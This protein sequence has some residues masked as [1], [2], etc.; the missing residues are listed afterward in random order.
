MHEQPFEQATEISSKQIGQFKKLFQ[1]FSGR[2]KTIKIWPE[3]DETTFHSYEE[4]WILYINA[5]N[6]RVMNTTRSYNPNNK[7]LTRSY[8]GKA[9]V[10]TCE[11]LESDIEWFQGYFP[12]STKQALINVIH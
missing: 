11:E 9:K 1:L 3:N 7:T 6:S 12:N 8:D 2:W 4:N 5:Q 10:L